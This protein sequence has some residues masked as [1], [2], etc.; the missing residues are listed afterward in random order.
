[1]LDHTEFDPI[2]EACKEKG[3]YEDRVCDFQWWVWKKNISVWTKYSAP[4]KLVGGLNRTLLEAYRSGEIRDA[5]PYPQKPTCSVSFTWLDEKCESVTE[6]NASMERMADGTFL[7]QYDP[8]WYKLPA[9][10]FDPLV[11]SDT[12]NFYRSVCN[13]NE[14]LAICFP[15]HYQHFALGEILVNLYRAGII[16]D[17]GPMPEKPNWEEAFSIN[18][19]NGIRVD[20]DKIEVTEENALEASI[21]VWEYRIHEMKMRGE[22]LGAHRLACPL[23]KIYWKFSAPPHSFVQC[24]G[25]PIYEKTR[26]HG[27]RNT[28]YERFKSARGFFT[29]LRVCREEIEFLKSLRK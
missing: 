3:F 2:Y 7:L 29:A 18:E 22:F 20:W 19:N 9:D 23:C 26:E 27:C 12:E 11:D 15:N 1:M 14:K 6:L 21:A 8:P 13:H 10:V 4:T 17:K 24:F 28:P 16:R 25:C 5:G